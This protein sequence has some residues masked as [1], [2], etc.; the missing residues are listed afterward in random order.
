MARLSYKIYSLGC[1]VNQYD[2][3]KLGGLLKSAGFILAKDK[4]DF[5]IINSCAV[6]A[7]AISKSR[8][9]IKK[10]R[11]ENSRAKIVLA[12][13]WPRIIEKDSKKDL[14]VDLI[15]PK[16]DIDSLMKE[17][18]KY[19]KYQ[20]LNTKYKTVA[21]GKN[22]LVL[23]KD[24]QQRSRY[25][26]KIQDGCEQFCSYCIIPY[27][28]GKLQSRPMAEVVA[29]AEAAV[30]AGWQE[31]V[32]NGIHLG[33][34][35]INNVGNKSSSVSN[36]RNYSYKGR[37]NNLLE[38]LK[39]IVEIEGLK[40][41]RLS[42]IEVTEVGDDLIKFMAQEKKMCQHLHIPLQS[43]CNK[44]LK[45]MKRPYDLNFFA[46]KIKKLR[47]KMPDIAISTDVIVGFP[48]ETDK[49]FIAMKNFI[50][51]IKFSRLHVFSFSAHKRTAAFKLPDHV[52]PEIIKSRSEA[53]RKLSD[54]LVCAY[55]K[56]FAGKI[57]EVV[58]EQNRSSRTGK[59]KGDKIKGKTQFY[60]DV[61]FDKNDIISRP[62]KENLIGQVVKIKNIL[63][64][65]R[66]NRN[67]MIPE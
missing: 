37:N 19:S 38:L 61:Y 16:D 11:Q 26:L 33:L 6:T 1:K 45:S 42:S 55:E 25:F 13:C 40:R 32:L 14:D 2:G 44:I 57:L 46:E 52:K 31:I 24:V 56:K 62:A 48:G 22:G 7:S 27:T 35:G 58:V 5:A 10:A 9:M 3:D 64:H 51:K 39:K 41:I 28:R 23:V 20:I 30:Q 17:I 59:V 4:A 15:W 8:A 53:L 36:T 60:F 67:D 50:K 54:E 34:Y 63:R 66:L 21:N 29:E 18:K 43:G 65:S 47:K 49:D 12:G